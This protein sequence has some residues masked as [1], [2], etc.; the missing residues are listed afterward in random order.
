MGKRK[1]ANCFLPHWV[2]KARD[3]KARLALLRERDGDLCWCCGN[4]MVFG[5]PHPNRGRAATIEHVLPRSRGGT[6]ALDN[7]RLCHVGCNRH[8]ADRDP[9]QKEQM[10]HPRVRQR[11]TPEPIRPA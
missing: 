4:R 11:S 8:L 7:L 6:W 3:K 1:F 9:A 10:R 5:G 2:F